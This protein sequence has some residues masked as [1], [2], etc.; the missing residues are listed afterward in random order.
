MKSHYIRK[1]EFQTSLYRKK[2]FT[3]LQFLVYAQTLD[4]EIDSLKSTRYRLV[5]FRVQD[6][7][8]YTGEIY[9]YYQLKKL[10]DFF[11]ELQINSLIKFFSDT[12]YRIL[13][14]ISQVKLEKGK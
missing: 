10:L 9:N 12:Q 13:V 4:Y 1:I 3:L 7:L 14:R 2:F 8:R 6:F 11:N 5:R